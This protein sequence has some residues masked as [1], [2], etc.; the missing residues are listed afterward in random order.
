MVP[1]LIVISGPAGGYGKTTLAHEVARMIGCPAICRDEIK[2]GMVHANP[3]FEPGPGD[4]LT[5]KALP[6]FFEALSLLLRSGTTVVAEAAFQDD[7]W[8]PGLEPLT[9]LADIRVI[10]CTA[11]AETARAR[12]ARRYEGNVVRK[13]AHTGPRPGRQANDS[14]AA[15][16][17]DGPRLLVDTTHGYDPGLDDIATFIHRGAN[18]S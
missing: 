7:L 2:E 14:F 8:R 9:E 18:S 13:A 1:T 4:P 11:D 17:L 15:I 12:N 3:G 6:L 5:Q 10:Q 16:S